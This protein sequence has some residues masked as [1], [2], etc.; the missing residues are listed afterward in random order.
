MRRLTVYHCTAV[1]GGAV[2]F[3]GMYVSM[4]FVLHYPRMQNWLGPLAMSVE[5][6]I[7]FI[8]CGISVVVL[9]VGHITKCG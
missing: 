6:A 5:S 2:W 8:A 4:G 7:C 9:S 1:L 3:A